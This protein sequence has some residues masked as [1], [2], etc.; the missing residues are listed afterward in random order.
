MPNWCAND[1]TISGKTTDINAMVELFDVDANGVIIFSFEKI[2][3]TPDELKNDDLWSSDTSADT[4][5]K[6][7]KRN[8]PLTDI[9]K[10][11]LLGR[12]CVLSEGVKEFLDD[13]RYI[14]WVNS[15]VLLKEEDDEDKIM[16]FAQ[17]FVKMVNRLEAYGFTGWYGWR[18][19]NWG[20]KW[21]V[22]PDDASINIVE[23][24]G[25]RNKSKFSS[26]FDTAW[27]P[28]LGVLHKLSE[29]FPELEIKVAF[30]EGGCCFKGTAKFKGGELI[31][32]TEGSYSGPR[33]G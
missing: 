22:A 26:T 8:D 28:P 9:D 25:N 30:F 23:Y 33:G 11:S 20:T 31:S 5:A 16:S 17:D 2:Y 27:A 12:E 21:D 29:R 7:Y 18:V 4:I 6:Q 3:P 32:S 14:D 15:Y 24:K 13:S 19:A 10:V 1:L